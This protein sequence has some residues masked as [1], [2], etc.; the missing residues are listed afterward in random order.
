MT[1]GICANSWPL[2]CDNCCHFVYVITSGSCYEATE[3]RHGKF[4]LVPNIIFS[5]D[6]L[7]QSLNAPDWGERQNYHWLILFSQDPGKR[8]GG[9]KTLH[10]M[11]THVTPEIPQGTWECFSMYPVDPLPQTITC[12]AMKN[13]WIEPLTEESALQ[14]TLAFLHQWTEG[15]QQCI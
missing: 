6:I 13:Y 2:R 5:P 9:K 10:H 11:F 4:C 3:V 7:T 8:G 14:F 15:R 1:C 12:T